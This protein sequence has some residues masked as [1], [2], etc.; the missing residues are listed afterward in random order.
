[1][2]G[3]NSETP[4]DGTGFRAMTPTVGA[5]GLEPPTSAV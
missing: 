2:P 5:K 1:M 3:D 4:S